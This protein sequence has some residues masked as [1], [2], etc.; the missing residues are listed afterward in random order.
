MAGP[1]LL[2]KCWAATRSDH[3]GPSL[4]DQNYHEESEA[5]INHKI[6]LELCTSYLY[7]SLSYYFDCNNVALKSFAKYSLHQIS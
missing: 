1:P 6:S 5:T 7:L 3:Q 4:M 2:I